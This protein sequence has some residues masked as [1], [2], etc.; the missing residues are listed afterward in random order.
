M[1]DDRAMAIKRKAMNEQQ[2]GAI[3]RIM[4]DMLPL[5]PPPPPL[6]MPR[7]LDGGK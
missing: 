2:I 4:S 3:L 1:A 5:L 7:I 6:L